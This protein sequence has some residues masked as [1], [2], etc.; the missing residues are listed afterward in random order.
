MQKKKKSLK[1]ESISPSIF[2]TK[3]LI[4]SCEDCSFFIK[5]QKACEMGLNSK[6]YQNQQQ[7]ALYNRTGKLNICLFL[8]ID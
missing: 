7:K 8:E 6:I 3:Q 4:Y 5:K 1:Q 2:N